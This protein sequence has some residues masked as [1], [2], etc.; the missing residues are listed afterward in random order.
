[1]QYCSMVYRTF[2][3]YLINCDT[4]AAAKQRREPGIMDRMTKKAFAK[5]CGVSM[6][7]VYKWIDKDK[8]G[9]A[10]FVKED[11]IDPA[12]FD[13]E[14]WAA[15]A[16]EEVKENEALAGKLKELEAELAR[17]KED[18]E[19]Q[20]QQ[21]REMISLL[22]EQITANNRQLAEKDLQIQQL[23]VLMNNQLQA[24]PKPRRTPREWFA[25]TFG[26]GK[27]QEE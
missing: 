1:M 13:R 19:R 18:A 21:L 20:T 17:T 22:Q 4:I 12:V 23:H 8:D 24:L 14:P 9:L 5:R 7:T 16:A 26:K 3:H 25:D 15:F 10:A 2:T 6:P 27:K 11:G